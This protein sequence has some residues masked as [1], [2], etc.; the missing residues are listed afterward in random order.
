METKL[1]LKFDQTVIKFAKKYAE[2]N[3]RGLFKLV[4]YY[5]KNLSTENI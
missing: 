3:N 2:N 1:T 5:F 4:E